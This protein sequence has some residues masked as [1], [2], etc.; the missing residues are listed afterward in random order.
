MDL[1][2][3]RGQHE[4]PGMGAILITLDPED[5]ARIWELALAYFSDEDEGLF[6]FLTV[7]LSVDVNL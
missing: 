5:L 3:M 6:S 2:V 1:R 7:K 4:N